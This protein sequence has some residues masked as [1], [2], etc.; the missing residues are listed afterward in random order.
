MGQNKSFLLSADFL[1]YFAIMTNKPILS[2][3]E[4]VFEE[5]DVYTLI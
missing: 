5:I 4:M 1:G 2:Y 3:K